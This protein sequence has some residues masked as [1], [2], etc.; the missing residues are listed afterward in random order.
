MP[1]YFFHMQTETRTSDEDGLDLSS[2]IKARRQA[3][4]TCGEMMRDAPEGF[5]GSRPWNVTVTD[6][7]GLVLWEIHMDGTASAA[8]TS[9]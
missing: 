3:I 1:R 5:W 7:A 9:L 4:Q 2:P 6:A 8:A